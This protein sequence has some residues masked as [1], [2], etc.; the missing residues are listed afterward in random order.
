MSKILILLA[1][2]HAEPK[3]EAVAMALEQAKEAG[4]EILVYSPCETVAEADI[5]NEAQLHAQIA[6]IDNH[7]G[8]VEDFYLPRRKQP[9]TTFKEQKT[10]NQPNIIRA[11]STGN[12]ARKFR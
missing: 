11:H 4:A 6:C 5:L 3:I 12:R 1:A 10:P 2:A 8:A 7:F 9:Q